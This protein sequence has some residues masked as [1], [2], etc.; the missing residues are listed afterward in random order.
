MPIVR[1]RSQKKPDCRGGRTAD[2]AVARRPTFAWLNRAYEL[3]DPG[4]A[5]FVKADPMLESLRA[6]ARYKALLRKMK[7]PL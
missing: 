1:W 5:V 6:D 4:L 7:L 3:R 2:G